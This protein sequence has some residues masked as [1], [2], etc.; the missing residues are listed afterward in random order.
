[1]THVIFALTCPVRDKNVGLSLIVYKIM[2]FRLKCCLLY[3]S[4]I[5]TSYFQSF[6]MSS[7]NGSKKIFMLIPACLG[8]DMRVVIKRYFRL[9]Y[10]YKGRLNMHIITGYVLCGF[11]ISLNGF[12]PSV[13][14]SNVIFL[15]E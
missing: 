12:I 10:N 13:L 1:M 4:H 8:P 11:L 7:I 15:G 9:W 3:S 5:V 2:A 6:Y 14:S